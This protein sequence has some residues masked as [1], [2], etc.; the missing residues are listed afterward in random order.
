[1]KRTGVFKKTLLILLSIILAVTPCISEI[2][3]LDVSAK[4]TA[5]KGSY[6]DNIDEVVGTWS[7]N[8]N[9]YT[10]KSLLEKL[11]YKGR[12]QYRYTTSNYDE[13]YGAFDTSNWAT[14]FMWDLN[15]NK[16][17]SHTV[18][19]IPLA[20]RASVDG[21]DGNVM[22][23]TAPSALSDAAN[24]TYT[25]QMPSNGTVTDFLIRLPFA[26][27]SAKV[28]AITDWTYDVVMEKTGDSSTYMKTTMVQGSI[29]AYFEL[30]NANSLTIT[31]GRGLPAKKTYQSPGGNIIIIRCFDNM[32][33]DYD[34]YAF[35]GATGTSFNVTTKDAGNQI[36]SIGVTFSGDTYLTLA[37]LGSRKTEDDSWAQTVCTTYEPYAYN[38]VTDTKAE[39]SFDAASSKLKTTYSYTVAKKKESTADGTIMGVLP[40]Q[41]KNIT[42]GTNFSDYTYETVRG[43]MKTIAG[44]SFTTELTYSGILPYMPDYTEGDADEQAVLKGYLQDYITNFSGNYFGNYEGTGDTYWDGKGMNRLANAMAAAY[45][46][47]EKAS[48]DSMFNALK[49]RLEEW[50]TYSGSSDS[51]YFYYDKEVGALFGFPQ[52]YNSVDQIND[53][54]FHYGYFIYAAAQVAFR[55]KDF[56]SDY[57]DVVK[58][59][60]YDIA[61]PERNSSSSKYPYLRN[62]APYEGHSWASGHANFDMGNNQESSSEALNAWAGIIL[63]GEATGDTALRDLGIYLYTTEVSAVQNYWYDTDE[64]VLSDAYRYKVQINDLGTLNKDNAEVANNSAAIVWGG[65]Y[66]YATWFSANP[67]HIQGINLLPMN[68]TCFYLAGNKKYIKDNYDLAYKKA[69]A[70]NWNDKEWIDIWYQYY[71]MAYPEEALTKWKAV[72]AAPGSYGVEGGDTKAHTYHFIKTL[73]T[74]GTPDTSIT[75]DTTLSSV[76][77][78]DDG[79]KTYCAYN[80]ATSPKTVRFS[81]GHEITVAPGSMGVEVEGSGEGRIKYYTE[82]YLEDASGEFKLDITDSA[83][84]AIGTEVNADIREY[85]GYEIDESNSQN[86]LKEE[87]QEGENTVLKVYY[88]RKEY[89]I[90]YNLDD[91][92]Q[93]GEGNPLSYKYGAEV[94]LKDPV[95]EGHY[96]IGWYTDEACTEAFSGIGE[97]TAGDVTLWAKWLEATTDE[98]FY[99]V[100]Y[101]KETEKGSGNYELAESEVFTGKIGD[102]VFAPEKS[103]DGYVENT[104][105]AERVASGTVLEDGTLVLKLY[106]SMKQEE[107]HEGFGFTYDASTGKATFYYEGASGGIVYVSVY[108]SK[109]AAEE[110]VKN[111]NANYPGFD[112]INNEQGLGLT[113][114]EG[115]AECE[116]AI[117]EGKY[118]AYA[119]N[120][121]E[122]GVE[123]WYVG[124]AV[125]VQTPPQPPEDI[126]YTI[127]YYQQNITFDGYT[128]TATVSKTGKA[129]DKVQAEIRDY[130]GFTHNSGAE[131]SLLE[132][133]L[134]QGGQLELQ[135][136][137]DRDKYPVIYHNMDDAKNPN[138]E[139][140][141]FGVE[142]VLQNPT[143]QGYQFEG[144]YEDE[145]CESKIELIGTNR[146]GEVNLYAKWIEKPGEAKYIVRHFLESK[147]EGVY[148]EVIA[149]RYEGSGDVGETVNAIVNEYPG[150]ELNE[151]AEGSGLTGVLSAEET[152]VLKAYY[153]RKRYRVNYYNM[154]GAD[155]S[156]GNKAE[157]VYGKGFV[158]QSPSR[159]NYTFGGW[160][161]DEACSAGNEIA[162]ITQLQ[163]GELNIYAKWIKE[164]TK[165]TVRYYLQNKTQ[166]GYEENEQAAEEK[167]ADAGM[168]VDAKEQGLVKEFIGYVLNEEYEGGSLSGTADKQGQLILKLYYDLQ[169]YSVTYANM[170]DAV[171]HEDN[172]ENYVYGTG[173][174]LQEPEREGFV[175]GGWYLDEACTED[176]RVSEIKATDVGDITL[177]AKWLEE[178]KVASYTVHY[179]LQNTDLGGYTEKSEDLYKGNAEIGTEVMAS[180]REFEGFEINEDVQ[181]FVKSGIVEEDGSLELKIYYDRCSY[182]IIYHNME[183]AINPSTNKNSYVYGISVTLSEPTKDGYIFGGWYTMADLSDE[184]KVDKI[185]SGQTGV[186]ELYAKWTEYAPAQE[187]P[188]VDEGYTVETIQDQYYTGSK[189]VPTIVVKDG[190][191]VLTEKVDYTVKITNNINAGQAKIKIT[192]KGNYGSTIEKI[193]NILPVDIGSDKMQADDIYVAYKNGKSI[194]VSPKL[195]WGN[196]T[197]KLN[198]DYVITGAASYSAI[199]SYDVVLQGKGNYTGSRTI[200]FEIADKTLMSSVKVAKIPNQYYK[201]GQEIIP[202]LTVTYKGTALAE[203]TDYT[204]DYENNMQAGTA[205]AILTGTGGN[206]VGKKKVT[207]KIIGMD[208]KKIQISLYR[209]EYEYTGNLIQPKYFSGNLKAGKDFTVAYSNN[210]KVGT[211]TVTFTGVGAYSGTL[212]KTFKI[213]PYNIA[214]NTARLFEDDTEDLIVDY[215]KGGSKPSLELKFRSTILTEGTD[216][217]LKYKNNNKLG[218]ATITVTGK[219]SFTGSY[220][221]DFTI[222]SAGLENVVIVADDIVYKTG[223]KGSYYMSKVSLTD[224]SGKKLSAGTDYDKQFTYAY[225][226]EDGTERT[227][228]R[229]SNIGDLPTGTTLKV[230]ITGTGNYKG[231]VP[232]EYSVVPA[233]IKSAKV[234]IAQQDYTGMPVVLDKT[235]ITVTVGGVNLSADQFEIVDTSY[236]NN[237]RKGTAKVTI[238]GIGSYGGYKTVS[239]KIGT[240][241]VKNI[242]AGIFGR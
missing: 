195:T 219:G 25:M 197:L 104:D 40:H 233:S 156:A 13:N 236:L 157:Y 130:T 22:Q 26:T 134:V 58:Q 180:V 109:E 138:A 110:A 159:E 240:R 140:Y 113:S 124:Q 33:N 191:K 179:Y 139:E 30:V 57:G 60:I 174:V 173:F 73:C 54:H 199:G 78:D 72:E 79:V 111:A 103:Y 1:M 146:T 223:Q 100:E 126:S 207:F 2:G 77:V 27:S 48:G 65:S 224:I 186:L 38:F 131:G 46:A 202:E 23:V 135:V 5:A 105:H 119:F 181:D 10:N 14:S 182:E 210:K 232:V 80:A 147:I 68:P 94:E 214:N 154:E 35:Y 201:D 216:Y 6:A 76:F 132:G 3:T 127:K 230:T 74:Y 92:V 161:L 91:S 95:W 52:S 62:F 136:Y 75:S 83:Y 39:Y 37:Y 107:I 12:D 16:P 151:N 188:G 241:S 122:T 28:D 211:G 56:A 228:D 99:H 235:D 190:E 143:R 51:T 237:T 17:Y 9:S 90:T 85:T 50:F 31:R 142:L 141:V 43:T 167:S 239:F 118:F 150:Y 152:I 24:N 164:Q 176:K 70:A 229:N 226:A 45:A 222:Q 162:E 29:F 175:F 158:L 187:D 47:G 20:F 205:T 15:G 177:Y 189:I 155:N 42:S 84:G 106:Y 108:D 59:L 18:Y 213:T 170:A 49:D 7:A 88:K 71:A 93:N 8:G 165:Y 149:D 220:T 193:F 204:V 61:C 44:S 238:H 115:R 116:Y 55:D 89:Q 218:P 203:N 208:L 21:G 166:D 128:E 231:S 82:Y 32:D 125:E 194:K 64:D 148:S 227:F 242:I 212:K 183:D 123:S 217:T 168:W 11:P 144:W 96:F 19:A 200:K 102:V 117:E 153:D 120:P 206:Y 81:D 192:G 133:E 101:Y 221:K 86:K 169:T 163:S 63:W 36:D 172:A 234:K 209:Q 69:A 171:N 145:A 129:G 121:N 34:Y 87:L 97:T 185:E 137:Y 184:S 41:Y 53:H 196:K 198:K 66:T 114:A 160:Y 112:E 178:A 67:L 225:V 215:V 4:T 98:T